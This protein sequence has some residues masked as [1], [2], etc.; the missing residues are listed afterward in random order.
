MSSN[1]NKNENNSF[2]E[3][4]HSELVK[5]C[6]KNDRS[7]QNKLYSL[8]A[9]KML[10]VCFRY[11]KSREDAEDILSEG[12]VRVFDKLDTYKGIGSLEGWIR[13]IMVHTAIEK[14]RKKN[15]QFAEF[16]AER[17]A[18]T[19]RH[20]DNNDIHSTINA[21]ELL[22]LVQKLPPAYQMVFN[23]YAFEGLKHKEIAELL[24]IS[25]GTSKSNLSDARERLKKGIENL[26]I[27]KLPAQPHE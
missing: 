10:A 17:L 13:R 12:F 15:L 23:L 18:D 11:S 25:E 21:K 26:S 24:G 1:I 16:D 4:A 6:L 22:N 3:E 27:E 20:D 7:A 9:R 2:V 8:F 19:T 5:K 14:F